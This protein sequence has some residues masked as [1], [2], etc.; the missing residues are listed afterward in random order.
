MA[1]MFGEKLKIL[2][3]RD[4]LLK[5]SDE[6]HPVTLQDILSYLTSLDIAAERKSIYRDLKTLG[7]GGPSDSSEEDSRTGYGMDI[8]KKKDRYYLRTRD[9]T[10]QEVKILIDMV[11][12]SNSITKRKTTELIDK[13]S[14]LVSVYEAKT[15]NRTVYV[16]NRVKVMN[17]SVYRNV[18]KISEAI[19]NDEIIRFQYFTY[20][21]Q[22]KKELRHQGKKHVVSPFALIW[23]DQNYYLLG[24]NHE[25]QEMRPFR[26]DRMTA[27][28]TITGPRQ[29]KNDFEKIDIATFTTKVFHMYTGEIKLVQMRFQKFLVDAVIDRFGE[30]VMISPD[31]EDTFTVSTEVAISPQFY[32][33]LAGFGKN[34]EILAPESVR[35]GMAEHIQQIMALYTC[36]K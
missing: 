33:W 20:N 29:G 18:D 19:N 7:K 32:G 1:K 8:V 21:L 13:I 15:L 28:T 34:V 26:V 5:Y 25:Y 24:Y 14:A 17:E 12:S 27:V 3:L 6:N 30:D 35:E 31:G 16:R 11:Q 36:P 23:V 22:K 4:F 10:L 2:Y 9:F